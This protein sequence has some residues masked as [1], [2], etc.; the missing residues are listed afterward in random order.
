MNTQTIPRFARAVASPAARVSA[1]VARWTA[2]ARTQA[3][4]G[5]ALR[6]HRMGAWETGASLRAQALFAAAEARERV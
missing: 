2:C 6:R 3:D 5:T 1:L 4:T